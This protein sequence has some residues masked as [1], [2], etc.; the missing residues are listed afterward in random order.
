MS[1]PLSTPADVIDD[2]EVDEPKRLRT[3]SVALRLIG[4][5]LCRAAIWFV[6][7][8]MFWGVAPL[9]LG[10]HSTTVMSGSMEPRIPV[11]SVVVV[12]PA[13][14]DL[15]TPGR[16][17]Q[18]DDPD[19]PGR[20]RLHRIESV[21]DAGSLVTKGDA[22]QNHDSSPVTPAQV[23]GIGVVLVPFLGIPVKAVREETGPSWRSYRWAPSSPPLGRAW[24]T[25]SS[26]RT[27]RR[28]GRTT[29]L[30]QVPDRTRL[31]ALSTGPSLPLR[32][33][34]TTIGTGSRSSMIS[35]PHPSMPRGGGRSRVA[36][37]SE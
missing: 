16:V 13:G 9:A 15:L 5:N 20:L 27:T 2:P 34:I 12:M 14:D 17:I 10:W 1:A 22:N 30:E 7:G 31:P 29:I 35:M 23:R 25:A 8:P 18:S 32:R 4:A 24:T 3:P 28:R 21:D 19:H 6:V 11:G 26:M 37:R 33:R 36:T